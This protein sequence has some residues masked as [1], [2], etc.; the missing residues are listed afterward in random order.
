MLFAGQPVGLLIAT[1]QHLANKAAKRVKVH[2]K[3]VK[4]PLTSTQEVLSSG[5]K[6]RIKPIKTVERKLE[7]GENINIS[8]IEVHKNDNLLFTGTCNLK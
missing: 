5:D 3:D 2:V 7:N 6:S 4:K 8:R 1:S